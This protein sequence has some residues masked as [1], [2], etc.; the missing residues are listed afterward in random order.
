MTEKRGSVVE[1]TPL[2]VVVDS[3]VRKASIL[4]GAFSLLMVPRVASE[5]S[6]FPKKD[7]EGDEGDDSPS[8]H[9]AEPIGA[10][11]DMDPVFA[12]VLEQCSWKDFTKRHSWPLDAWEA[13]RVP[14]V[15]YL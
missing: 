1:S 7:T 5:S 9:A 14:Q 6:Y 8:A 3:R 13:S 12:D 4:M 2:T 10:P 11:A 15:R